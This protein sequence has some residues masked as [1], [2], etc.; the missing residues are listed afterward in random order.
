MEHEAYACRPPNAHMLSLFKPPA[1]YD[2]P[3]PGLRWTSTCRTAA[4]RLP[5]RGL[6]RGKCVL[7]MRWPEAK[8]KCINWE[9]DPG[10]IEYRT[11]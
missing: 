4:E 10:H 2:L 3:R 6:G 11:N 8:K 5:E 1:L 9:S 7:E